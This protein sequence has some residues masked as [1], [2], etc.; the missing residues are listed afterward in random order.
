[1][2]SI[3]LRI[4][5][6]FFTALLCLALPAQSKEENLLSNQG[7][8]AGVGLSSQ[9]Y[10][11]GALL[12]GIDVLQQESVLVKELLL[13]WKMPI[14]RNWFLGIEGVYG[15]ATDPLFRQQQNIAIHYENTSHYSLGVQLSR[16][17][18]VQKSSAFLVY[19]NLTD[20]RFELTINT[21]NGTLNQTDG[22][23]F[24]RYGIG[25]EH[26]LAHNWSWRIT[27]GGNYATFG[28]LQTNINV[29]DGVDLGVM[30]SYTF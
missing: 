15:H 14:N 23:S 16:Y 3:S 1:M 29:N 21:A 5:N 7:F 6:L 19:A 18:N 2:K 10:F 30:A 20:R 28:N 24:L 27:L 22:Q 11:S 13:G 8:Y 9:N 17:L 25:Y 4:L 12:D 26:N